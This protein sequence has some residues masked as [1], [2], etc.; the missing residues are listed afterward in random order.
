[1]SLRID[2][3]MHYNGYTSCSASVS[4]L[5]ARI[6]DFSESQPKANFLEESLEKVISFF[7]S[8]LPTWSYLIV[9]DPTLYPGYLILSWHW[10]A[11]HRRPAGGGQWHCHWHTTKCQWRIIVGLQ[12][13][14]SWEVLYNILKHTLAR[15]HAALFNIPYMLHST[16]C[17]KIC[18]RL[19]GISQLKLAAV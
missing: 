18:D 4:I 2:T 9:I 1:M 8:R 11:L 7:L 16:S 15:Q 13:L 14:A 12:H 19:N 10:A 5:W 17:Y 3:R 6:L